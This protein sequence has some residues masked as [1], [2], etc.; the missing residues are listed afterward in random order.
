MSNRRINK[1][2]KQDANDEVESLEEKEKGLEEEEQD[3]TR[4]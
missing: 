1:E 2:E 4:K 3:R